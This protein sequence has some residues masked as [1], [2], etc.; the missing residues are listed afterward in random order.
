[1]DTAVETTEAAVG[2]M[3]PSVDAGAQT[4][5]TSGSMPTLAQLRT[6]ETA[7]GLD[8]D[9]YTPLAANRPPLRR[10]R[11]TREPSPMASEAAEV[12]DVDDFGRAMPRVRAESERA[13]PPTE[14][15]EPGQ[16]GLDLP[17]VLSRF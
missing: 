3:A 8:P 13:D 7:L 15:A 1:M 12:S 10:V 9:T 5:S 16:R 17:N 6:A 11:V 4:E 2:P 14:L